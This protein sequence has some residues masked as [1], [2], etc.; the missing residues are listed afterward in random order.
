M[1]S[2]KEI[3]E[4]AGVS[5]A[6]VSRILNNPNHKCS[7]KEVRDKVFK[8][9]H[10]LNYVPNEAA[11]ALKKGTKEQDKIYYLD[12]L[13]TRNSSLEQDEFFNEVYHALE[14]EF[15]KRHCILSG[16]FTEEGFSVEE[17]PEMDKVSEKIKNMT[18]DRELNV[19]GLIVLGKCNKNILMILRKKYKAVV[20]INRNSTDYA[21]DEVVCDGN[22]LANIAMD[23]LI[24]LG[25]KNIGYVGSCHHE[26]RY[27]GY[28][29]EMFRHGLDPIPEN[30]LEVKHIEMEGYKAME[31]FLKMEN[32]PSAFYCANDMVAIGMLKCLEKNKVKY[33]SPS[34]ISSDDIEAAQFSKP[35]LTTVHIDKQAMARFATILLIDRLN[36]KHIEAVSMKIDGKLMIRESCTRVDEANSPEYII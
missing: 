26:S 12:V 2:L 7:N 4:R 9:A 1:S 23:Y 17:N 13:L 28:L 10:E 22:H 14:L 16:F 34:I 11:K 33:Y 19:D 21:V 32:R 35:M 36:G 3:A 25:H 27:T 29:Q 18:D 30:V 8:A 20:S 15:N 24:K 31:Y 6:T 5:A